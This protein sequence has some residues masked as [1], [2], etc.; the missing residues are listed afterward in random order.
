MN[1]SQTERPAFSLPYELTSQIFRLCLPIRRRVRPDPKR[2]PLL[3]AQICSQWRAVALADPGLWSSIYLEFINSIPKT[4][5][6]PDAEPIRNRICEMLDLWLT[7]AAGH[8]LSITLICADPYMRFPENVIATVAACS[9]TWGRIELVLPEADLLDFNE[10]AGP[11]PLLQSLAI[12]ISNPST[13]TRPMVNAVSRSPNL[14]ALHL[15][16]LNVESP[17][18][19]GI[20]P[21][22]LTALQL[23]T[24]SAGEQVDRI[25][26]IFEHFP[27][28]L[29][30]STWASGVDLPA[31]KRLA[32]PPLKS[33]LLLGNPGL[34]DV[35]HIP[36]LE[37]LEV[38]LR[39]NEDT[40]HV[41]PFLSRSK[42]LKHLTM[43][44]AYVSDAKAITCLW[45]ARSITAL[46]F[47]FPRRGASH[48]RYQI[49]ERADLLPQLRTI[50]ITDAAQEPAYASFLSLL[51]A[52]P[53]VTH[54]EL[55]MR[56]AR[57]DRMVPLGGNLL[58]K[59]EALASQGLS[60]RVTTPKSVWPPD[61]H[62]AEP[63]GDLDYDDVF[64]S[65]KTRPYFFSPF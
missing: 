34:L 37:H 41:V 24:I 65:F 50:I 46:E 26:E 6:I 16:L 51:C 64:K 14:R 49:L 25:A 57:A 9:S 15:Y 44:I 10:I 8:P 40:S 38:A 28:L 13:F 2:A 20:L 59:F 42:S 36:T 39:A 35:L 27:N 54:A 48:A 60:I 33:L 30:F 58:P 17:P 63:V 56:P 47:L 53:T 4:A 19:L 52:K 61:I 31:G 29:H 12:R 21:A 18:D 23:D 22:S 3:L 1:R 45:A 43:E 32:S 7:R 62:E 55:H 11:F 5:K